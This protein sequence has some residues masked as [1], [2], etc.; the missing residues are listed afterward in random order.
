LRN[1]QSCID[2]LSKMLDARG[3]Q[4]HVAVMLIDVCNFKR[5]NETL[6]HKVG[7]EVLKALAVRL[8]S[9]AGD[10]D[11]LARMGGDGFA[12]VRRVA[13]MSDAASFCRDVCSGAA[14]PVD[15]DGSAI[16]LNVSVGAALAPGH[17]DNAGELIQ[18]AEIAL[19]QTK[20]ATRST[21]EIFDP[22]LE[23]ALRERQSLE[24]DLKAAFDLGQLQLHYQPIIDLKSRQVGTL[25]AL[26]RW[27]HPVRGL[28]SPSVFIPIAEQTGLIVKIGQWAVEQACRDAATWPDHVRVAVNLSAAQFASGNIHTI[29]YRALRAAGLPSSRL[30]L[31]VTESLLLSDE[32]RTRRILRRIKAMGVAVALDDFGTGY[33]SLSYLRSFP[34]DKIK[35]D[36]TFVRDLPRNA[37]CY[38]IV[39]SVVSLARM[40][41]MK[42]VAEGIETIEH[43][44][45]V[46]AAGCDEVQGYHFSRPV[47][48]SD[49]ASVVA[50]CEIRL[51][52]AA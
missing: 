25:E 11:L 12:F 10:G 3:D 40:L 45:Q 31:E 26:M 41:G 35:I 23:N 47:I 15:V 30:E 4:Q 18:R 44:D 24:A 9:L 48:A 16:D 19:F 8:R 6:G 39:R 33:A 52:E 21:Y 28:V 46:V 29:V 5:V 50:E 49:V 2:G 38:A 13:S 1:R 36:Q 42:T 51:R 27:Q 14:G 22:S 34:F 32:A 37:D 17:A 43:L 7:D 20:D